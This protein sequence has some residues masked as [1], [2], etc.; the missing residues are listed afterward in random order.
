MNMKQVYAGF[1]TKFNVSILLRDKEAQKEG[2]K[3]VEIIQKLINTQLNHFVHRGVIQNTHHML[4]FFILVFMYFSFFFL[5]ES[6]P[7]ELQ[8]FFDS[9]KGISKLCMRD[10]V[11]VL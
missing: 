3:T 8:Q 2:T 4:L 1:I 5:G 10:L 9:T 11:L 6:R 7:G